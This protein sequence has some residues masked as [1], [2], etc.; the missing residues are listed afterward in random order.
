MADCFEMIITD[1]KFDT[2]EGMIAYSYTMSKNTVINELD[3]SDN[4][5]YQKLTYYEFLE[6]LARLVTA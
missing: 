4:A 1:S 6:F 3:E 2:S 5:K